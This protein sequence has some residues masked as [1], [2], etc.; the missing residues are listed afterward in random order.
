MGTI[1]ATNVVADE[2][3]IPLVVDIAL[4]N[5]ALVLPN[6][7]GT[8]RLVPTFRRS[9]TRLTGP[10]NSPSMFSSKPASSL[11]PPTSDERSA[12]PSVDAP[13]CARLP[14]TTGSSR[15][16]A[17]CVACWV[18][19]RND[20]ASLE[21][22]PPS[23]SWVSASR[24]GITTN[25]PLCYMRSKLPALPHANCSAATAHQLVRSAPSPL[26]IEPLCT[27]CNCQ[28]SD[29]LHRPEGRCPWTN[30]RTAGAQPTE[31]CRQV[32]PFRLARGRANRP[33]PVR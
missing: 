7:A 18:S 23:A 3:R 33:R 5:A 29:Y 26:V 9:L 32:F 19:R 4:T 21:K 16:R 2:R 13:F 31:H 11:A 30:R 24:F 10:V 22:S 15:S 20:P 6:K 17:D 1:I 8:S 12:T 25:C 14:I 28:N 27:M